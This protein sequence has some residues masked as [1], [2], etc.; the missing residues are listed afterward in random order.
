MSQEKYQELYK[1][2]RATKWSHLIGQSQIAHSIANDVR[3]NTL[4]T[5]YGLFGPPG[6]GKTSI[7]KILA[8]SINCEK[9]L[10][11]E[12]AAKTAEPC[13][14]CETCLRI[15]ANNQ[16]G[17]RYESMANK[18]SVEDVRN[19]VKE[20]HLSQPVVRQ[21]WILD[22]VHNLSKQAFDALLIPIEDTNIKPLFILCSTEPHKVPATIMS[23]ISQRQLT[24]VDANTMLK[25]LARISKAEGYEL[26]ADH[27][28]EAVRRGRGS[29]RDS[30]SALE[31]IRS[32]VSGNEEYSTLTVNYSTQLI[33]AVHAKK[34]Y[35]ALAVIAQANTE[36]TDFKVLL[37][38]LFSDFRDMMILAAGG[39]QS[40]VTVSGL[41]NP[42]AVAKDIGYN[43][44]VRILS[45]LGTALNNVS[46]GG[47]SRIHLEIAMTK[48]IVAMN[49]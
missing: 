35:A 27:L 19:L 24:N 39:D 30:L 2:Y 38:E 16:P 45:F 44:I 11:P 32:M 6:V 29:V 9:R 49:S 31:A 20:A 26:D 7:A 1:K 36:G 22:E 34:L 18:G 33:Q 40:L 37:E 3:Q 13:N 17:V 28:K 43:N 47:D 46:F 8:K 25:H 48:S 10:D 4:P 15:D 42:M 23:R 5:A 14:E 41:E 21:V 12:I